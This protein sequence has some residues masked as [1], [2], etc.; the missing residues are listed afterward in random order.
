MCYQSNHEKNDAQN[1][2]NQRRRVS[3]ELSITGFSKLATS[4]HT[5]KRSPTHSPQS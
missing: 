5:H 2:D 1:S 3:V 4:K